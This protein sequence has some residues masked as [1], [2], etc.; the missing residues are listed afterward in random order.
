MS[1]PSATPVA[2]ETSGTT[3]SS[4]SSRN[5]GNGNNSRARRRTE[6]SSTVQGSDG[7]TFEGGCPEIGAVVGL[8]TEK[9]T[10]K[11]PFS[12]FVEKLADYV[13]TTFK[14]AADI[15][16]SIRCMVD[17]FEDFTD[18]HKPPPLMVENPS[19]DERYLQQERIKVYV[20]RDNALRDNVIKVYGLTW[21]QCTSALQ[22]VIKGWTIT[23]PWLAHTIWCGCLSI[24]RPL[25]RAST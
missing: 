12:V 10:K 16:Q 8:R 19:F 11:V 18:T 3:T 2:N 5:T 7:S 13:I 4:S 1:T 23:P 20:V 6:G 25:R 15:E 17:P 24:L 14:H 21:R 9:I 22:M